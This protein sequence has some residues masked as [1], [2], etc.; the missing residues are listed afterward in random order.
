MKFGKHWVENIA[1]SDEP[2]AWVPVVN[3]ISTGSACKYRLDKV[4]GQLEL[5][6]ALPRDV[7]FPT[8]YG[9][10]PHTRSDADDEET[11]VMILSREPL[12]PLTIVR[13][14]VVGGFVEKPSDQSEPEERLIAAAVD[15][16]EVADVQCIA[17]LD[18]D[19]RA[20][21]EAFVRTYKQNQDVVVSFEGWFD[22]DDALDRLR[23]GFKRAKK[24]AAK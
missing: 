9:F 6:R 12:L 23:R 22:R 15:D 20:S 1:R 19:L 16:P 8:N 18:A 4:T 21:I 24:R 3:E 17:D 2:E 14:R 7:A 10:V 11:D 13:A 5:A